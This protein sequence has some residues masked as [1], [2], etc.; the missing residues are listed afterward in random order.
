MN[1][2]IIHGDICYAADKNTLVTRENGYLVCVDG[3][4]KGVFGTVPEQYAHLAL[5]EYG[6]MLVIPG[7]VDLHIHAPQYHHAPCDLRHPAQRS[8]RALDG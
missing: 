8:D 6:G 1:S 3:I 7:M 5:R 4:C 2:F